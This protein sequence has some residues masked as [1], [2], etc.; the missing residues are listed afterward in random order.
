M[1]VLGFRCC[2]SF[3]LVVASGGYSLAVMCRLL[4][5]GASLVTSTGSRCAGISSCGTW[6][7]WLWV[8]GFVVL[9]HEESSQIW[10]W[11][12]VPCIGRQILYHWAPREAPS[13]SSR[14]H[15]RHQ[16]SMHLELY[17]TH[18]ES[19]KSL[20]EAPCTRFK[21]DRS[22]LLMDTGLTAQLLQ[23]Y[24]QFTFNNALAC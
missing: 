5:A 23:T 14:Q 8:M 4:I 16:S 17:V 3:P 18:S 22:S 11:T 13:L 20:L 21:I 7:Q 2:A 19:F 1:T 15:G 9:E 10:D 6:A 24:I 12:H